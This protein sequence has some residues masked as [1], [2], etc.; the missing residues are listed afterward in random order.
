M[1]ITYVNL[2]FPTWR[3]KLQSSYGNAFHIRFKKKT[4]VHIWKP[5]GQNHSGQLSEI[6]ASL[7]LYWC[8]V[9][10]TDN[11]PNLTLFR[12]KTSLN[13][14]A[15]CLHFVLPKGRKTRQLI[16][17]FVFMSNVTNYTWW[18]INFAIH[19]RSLILNKNL[20]LN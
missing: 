11:K 14:I 6:T 18:I 9:T 2:W 10:T 16:S 15:L 1:F 8:L 13:H 20:T 19:W 7:S 17:P 12:N 5:N 3:Y 4:I